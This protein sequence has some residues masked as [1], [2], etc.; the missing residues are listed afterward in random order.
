MMMA[1]LTHLGELTVEEFIAD[2]WQ[3][4]PV[5]I[6]NGIAFQEALIAVDELAGLALEPEIESRL[7]ENKGDIKNWQVIHGP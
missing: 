7:I 5:C 1:P 3:K 4:K 6:R 2:Y